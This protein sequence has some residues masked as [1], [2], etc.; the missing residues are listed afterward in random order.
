MVPHAIPRAHEATGSFEQ[1]ER[2]GGGHARLW[3]HK[4]MA[5]QTSCGHCKCLWQHAAS[6]GSSVNHL[7]EHRALTRCLREPLSNRHFA[8]LHLAQ[9]R[10]CKAC[11]DMRVC[12]DSLGECVSAEE[13]KRALAM[14][15]TQQ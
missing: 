4:R 11:A 10:P 14:P 7:R 9:G 15:L 2:S 5:V 3:V 6:S 13:L 8:A 12:L 1:P